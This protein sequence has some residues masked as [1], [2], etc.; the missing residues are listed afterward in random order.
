MLSEPSSLPSKVSGSARKR[1]WQTISRTGKCGVPGPPSAGSQTWATL[2]AEWS[3]SQEWPAGLRIEWA[4]GRDL[5]C[6]RS[7]QMAGQVPGRAEVV[8]GGC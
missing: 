7:R 8:Q 1:P 6:S 3:H 5:P 2:Q 4:P